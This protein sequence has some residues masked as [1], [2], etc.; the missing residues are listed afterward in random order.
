[1]DR[2]SNSYLAMFF[3]HNK[4]VSNTLYHDVL[5]LC[6]STHIVALFS[7]KNFLVFGTIALSFLFDNYCL[8]MD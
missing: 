2:E 8:I 7:S 1:M 3:S 4:S 5:S 6:S